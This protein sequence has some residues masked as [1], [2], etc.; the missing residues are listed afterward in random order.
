MSDKNGTPHFNFRK[1]G[2]RD[3]SKISILSQKMG[4]IQK[5]ISASKATD[6][7]TP[8]LDALG[9]AEEQGYGIMLGIVSY[10]PDDYLR[11]GVIES[12]I[13]YSKPSEIMDVLRYGVIEQ[14]AE[15]I[16]K[17]KQTNKKK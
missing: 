5:Q 4:H 14:L 8:L 7:I 16:A 1:M 13:D 17:A 12:D 3:E 15:D 2:Y 9:D 10:L 6:D 11:E